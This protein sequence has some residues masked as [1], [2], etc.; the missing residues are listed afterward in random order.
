MTV[1]TV[2]SSLYHLQIEVGSDA[3]A[4]L[5]LCCVSVSHVGFNFPCYDADSLLATYEE[6]VRTANVMYGSIMA[7]HV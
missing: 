7:I 4:L 2:S 1:T 5:S 6:R 3:N